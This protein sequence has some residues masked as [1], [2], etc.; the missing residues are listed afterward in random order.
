MTSANKGDITTLETRGLKIQRLEEGQTKIFKLFN[1]LDY[2]VMQE[3]IR[4]PEETDMQDKVRKIKY[5]MTIQL[6][7]VVYIIDNRKEA[8]EL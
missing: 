1:K 2:L 5:N 8:I 4:F 7:D 3:I 6:E